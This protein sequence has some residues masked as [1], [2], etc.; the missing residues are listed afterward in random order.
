MVHCISHNL[1]HLRYFLFFSPSAFPCM[2]I[3]L[4]FTQILRHHQLLILRYSLRLIHVL[5]PSRRHPLPLYSLSPD[6]FLSRSLVLMFDQHLTHILLPLHHIKSPKHWHVV[7][8]PFTSYLTLLEYV[9][10]F[11]RFRIKQFLLIPSYCTISYYGHKAASH[12][13]SKD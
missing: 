1:A 4:K 5:V 10:P 12:F 7:S 11:M 2:I 8:N 3:V 6:P 9:L 13:D